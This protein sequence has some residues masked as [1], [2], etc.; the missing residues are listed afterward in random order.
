MGNVDEGIKRTDL[1]KTFGNCNVY[2]KRNAK[3]ALQ[4]FI[5]VAVVQPTHLIFMEQSMMH[6]RL[7]VKWKERE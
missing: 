2:S 5:A 3:T 4:D 6:M 1:V 7:D